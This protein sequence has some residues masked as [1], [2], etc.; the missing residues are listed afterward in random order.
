MMTSLPAL[1]SVVAG[2]GQWCDGGAS[3]VVCVGTARFCCEKFQRDCFVFILS[4]SGE[5]VGCRLMVSG[6]GCVRSRFDIDCGRRTKDWF[7]L[8]SC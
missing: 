6:L 8:E 1:E 2:T 7:G 4:R 5:G 3:D